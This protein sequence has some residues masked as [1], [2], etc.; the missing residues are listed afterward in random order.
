MT[1]KVVVE[2]DT[3]IRWD[4]DAEPYGTNQSAVLMGA[5][6]RNHLPFFGVDGMAKVA[7][8]VDALGL[9]GVVRLNTED[10]MCCLPDHP[11]RFDELLP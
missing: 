10:E 7:I 1:L 3:D 8:I 2:R 9:G 11:E 4:C 5:S 6:A